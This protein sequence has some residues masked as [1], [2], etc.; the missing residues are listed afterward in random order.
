MHHYDVETLPAGPWRNG[1]G[2]TREIASRPEGTDDFGWRASV[3]E[4]G[5]GGP[6]S[7]F[8]GVDRTLT[9]LSGDGVR[10]TSPGAFDRLLA[11]A[12]EPFAFSG[13]LA[14]TAELAGGPCRVLNLMVRRGHWTAEVDR[15][16]GPVVPGP[17]HSGV[18]HVLCGHWQAEA[19]NSV[20]TTGQGVWWDAADDAAPGAVVPFSPDAAALWADV[21]PTA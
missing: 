17:G 21:V 13:D 5:R 9:L 16:T 10:L 12:G 3:A 1:G 8:A 15:V 14:L 11:R 7:A 18:L 19:D 20:L 4:I 6:F 2:T